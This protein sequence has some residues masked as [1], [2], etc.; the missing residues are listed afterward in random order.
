MRDLGWRAPDGLAQL[1]IVPCGRFSRYLVHCDRFS[2]EVLSQL[3]E[4]DCRLISCG[5]G[6][7]PAMLRMVSEMRRIVCHAAQTLRWRMRFCTLISK[8]VILEG[9]EPAL[10]L[11]IEAG[12]EAFLRET[13]FTSR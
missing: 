9:L 8:P 10:S 7:F 4:V 11:R 5:F 6:Q 12:S 1:Q 13:G 2:L 3:K